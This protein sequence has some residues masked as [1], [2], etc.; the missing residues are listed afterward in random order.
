MTKYIQLLRVK[1]YAKNLLIFLPLLFSRNLFNKELFLSGV[2][3][4]ISFCLISSAVYIINDICDSDNDKTHPTKKNRPIA[5]GEIDKKT[6]IIIAI[7]LVLFTTVTTIFSCGADFVGIFCVFTYLILNILYSLY[8]KNIP[9]VDIAVLVSGFLFRLIFGSAIT[10]IDISKWLYLTVISAAFYFGLGKRRNEL[11]NNPSNQT[12]RV[13]QYYSYDFLD[14]NMYIC[15]ALTITFY[16]LWSVDSLTII[17]TNSKNMVW[18]V[19]LVILIF[20]KYSLNIE[21]NSDADP[22]EVLFKDKLLLAMVTLFILSVF[23]IIYF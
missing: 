6:A 16:S 10:D 15:M 9:I 12:R 21:K 18:T 7:L 17:R 14:K 20:L 4:F 13:L 2:I 11:K 8:L 5:N 1:H 23:G 3:G 22:I 19:P